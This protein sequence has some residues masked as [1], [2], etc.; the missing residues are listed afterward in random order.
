MFSPCTIFKVIQRLTKSLELGHSSVAEGLPSLHK[1]MDLMPEATKHNNHEQANQVLTVLLG[2]YKY[3]QKSKVPSCLW[4]VVSPEPYQWALMLTRRRSLP[5][6]VIMWSHEQS[7]AHPW[8][9]L[10]GHLMTWV[11]RACT[12]NLMSVTV[13]W[14]SCTVFQVICSFNMCSNTLSPALG[15]DVVESL[16]EGTLWEEV[17]LED[18]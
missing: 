1:V 15:A 7:A 6:S 14:Q 13:C 17:G 3:S 4:R 18:L 5:G 8:S 12:R 9:L 16:W 11:S 10:S 2:S